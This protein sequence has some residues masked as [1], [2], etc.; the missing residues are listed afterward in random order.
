MLLE[1]PVPLDGYLGYDIAL[2]CFIIINFIL[3][4]KIK[5]CLLEPAQ[6]GLQNKDNKN[7]TLKDF[8]KK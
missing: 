5:P 6:G 1:S 8:F 4:G 2:I 7:K 3:R